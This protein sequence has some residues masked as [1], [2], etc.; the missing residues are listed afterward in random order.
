MFLIYDHYTDLIYLVGL[1]YKEA[2]VN[3]E[4]ALAAVEARI[5]DGDWTALDSVG[6]PYDAEI[7]PQNYDPRR[8]VQTER[9][10]HAQR[11]HRRQPASGRAQPPASRQNPNARAGSLPP[12]AVVQPLPLHVLPRLRGDFQLFGASPEVHIKVKN[13]LAE[14]RPIAGTRRRGKNEK[15]DLGLE[16]ELLADV[17]EKAEHLMLVDLA[18]ERPGAHRP[19]GHGEGDRQLV[20][21]ALQAT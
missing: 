11:G 18:P 3:L 5:G 10:S 13:G 15:E 21:R 20:H 4:V 2:A 12:P 14:I 6:T 1:N 9:R 19:A 7:L 16:A 17:K 8:A